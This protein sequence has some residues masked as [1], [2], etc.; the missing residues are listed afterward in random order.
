MSSAQ[1]M[2]RILHLIAAV[3][4][5]GI[6]ASHPVRSADYRFNAGWYVSPGSAGVPFA[7]PSV[8]FPLPPPGTPYPFFLPNVPTPPY[9]A[10]HHVIDLRTAQGFFPQIFFHVYPVTDPFAWGVVRF[11]QI[12]GPAVPAPGPMLF[13]GVIEAAKSVS[14]CTNISHLYEPC[15]S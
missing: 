12:A 13:G 8:P 9:D 4:T 6:L 7:N 2:P 1:R 5:L 10:L 3:T 15:A 11:F 14:G